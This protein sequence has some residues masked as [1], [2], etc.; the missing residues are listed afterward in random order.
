MKEKDLERR[1][2]DWCREHSVLCY[3]FSSPARRGVPDRILIFPGGGVFFLELKS[4]ETRA[5]PTPLQA[6]KLKK[7]A[8]QGQSVAW[9]NDWDKLQRNLYCLLIDFPHACSDTFELL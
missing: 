8:D 5:K 1:L 9:S 4:P 7:L 2:V 3:K 6:R